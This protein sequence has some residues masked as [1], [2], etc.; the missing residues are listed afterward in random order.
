[1]LRIDL[2]ELRGRAGLCVLV[3]RVEEALIALL[4]ETVAPGEGGA[5]PVS[6]GAQPAAPAHPVR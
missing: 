6:S 2:D 4:T 3:D 1:V 5:T